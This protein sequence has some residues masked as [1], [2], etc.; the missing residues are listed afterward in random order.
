MLR[1]HQKTKVISYRG[2]DGKNK[3]ISCYTLLSRSY[4]FNTLRVHPLLSIMERTNAHARNVATIMFTYED[5]RSPP[6]A[7]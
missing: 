1:F 2:I 5:H 7:S 3:I 4:S 6:L